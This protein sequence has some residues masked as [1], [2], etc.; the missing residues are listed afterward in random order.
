MADVESL[1]WGEPILFPTDVKQQH[2][3]PRIFLKA[4]AGSDGLLKVPDLD[5]YD[6][7]NSVMEMRAVDLAL[8]RFF[9]EGDWLTGRNRLFPGLRR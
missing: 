1:G 8:R 2:Y 9:G 3:V 4:F 7:A 5:T 6:I